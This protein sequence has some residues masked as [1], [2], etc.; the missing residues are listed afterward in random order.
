MTSRVNIFSTYWLTETSFKTIL[1]SSWTYK[2]NTSRGFFS[3]NVKRDYSLAIAL[4][5]NSMVPHTPKA[6]CC[7][8]FFFPK[9]GRQFN[10]CVCQIMLHEAY[11]R[12]QKILSTFINHSSVLDQNKQQEQTV[13][14]YTNLEYA[15]TH[16]PLVQF[17]HF[18]TA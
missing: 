13:L 1:L 17:K 11:L 14:I 2:I 18:L 8:P 9:N 3:Y 7:C 15:E 10:M 12:T 5:K 4:R 6:W 16:I